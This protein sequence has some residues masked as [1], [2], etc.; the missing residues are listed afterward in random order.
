MASEMGRTG[1]D[2]HWHGCPAP[3]QDLFLGREEERLDLPAPS[4]FCPCETH[5]QGMLCPGLS[6]LLNRGETP[7]CRGDPS[8]PN[9][10]HYLTSKP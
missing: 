4:P 1:W 9:C 3:C 10:H 7:H 2:P 5:T 6:Y 8:L